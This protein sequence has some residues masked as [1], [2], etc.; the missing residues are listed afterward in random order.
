MNGGGG[1]QTQ[2]IRVPKHIEDQ[3]KVNIEL[4][5]AIAEQGP[6]IYGGPRIAGYTADQTAAQD[7]NRNAAT[8][9]RGAAFQDAQTANRGVAGFQAQ[10][11]GA[12]PQ[13]GTGRNVAAGKFTDANLSAYMNPFTGQVIDATNAEIMRQGD[14]ARTQTGAR[15][16]NKIWGTRAGVELG[17]LGQGVNRNVGLNTA[18]LNKDNFLQAQGQIST[19]QNRDL[20][21]QTTTQQLQQQAELANQR[22][23]QERD[24]A[25]QQ[26]AAQAAQIR[27]AGAGQLEQVG[28]TN[29]GVQAGMQDRLAQQGAQQQGVDQQNLDLAYQD[30][31]QQYGWPQQQL[32][33]RQGIVSG[34]PVGQTQAQTGGG[35]SAAAGALGGAASGAA[36]GSMVGMPWLGAGL[37]GAL[38]LMA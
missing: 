13:I 4:A 36:L 6:P 18:G 19:D 7:W 16:G 14:I 3:Q 8:Q 9:P 35:R 5:N 20:Q 33:L 10:P 26:A 17:Q 21:A 1:S 22:A 34:A 37:G 12:A 25:N 2:E 27:L 23:A 38:G 30:F 31:L 11:L 24:L 29:V 32:A 15:L 28:R